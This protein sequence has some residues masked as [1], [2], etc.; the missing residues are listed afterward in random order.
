LYN[1]AKFQCKFLCILGYIEGT[2]FEVWIYIYSICSLLKDFFGF[3][4]KH[5]SR[6]IS[7]CIFTQFNQYQLHTRISQRFYNSEQVLFTIFRSIYIFPIY[8]SL[9][10]IVFHIEIFSTTSLS[11]SFF[12]I[13]L[14]L[15]NIVF[16]SFK[17]KATPTS[18]YI[19]SFCIVCLYMSHRW[20]DQQGS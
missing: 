5:V 15:Q 16:D 6:C 14:K 1:R 10:Y 11:T 3:L 17:I 19:W 7:V 12:F 13:L 8:C 18:S 9:E 2:K 4:R 20:V